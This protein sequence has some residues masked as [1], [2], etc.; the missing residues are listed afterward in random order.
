[1]PCTA[2]IDWNGTGAMVQAVGSVAAIIATVLIARS[3]GRATRD[4]LKSEVVRRTE[5]VCSLAWQMWHFADEV[6][7]QKGGPSEAPI[8]KN[9][10]LIF[11]L[12]DRFPVDQM[13]SG[14]VALRFASVR[15]LAAGFND[16]Y[17]GWIAYRT[18]GE[19]QDPRGF[20]GMV[21][22]SR[23]IA[24]HYDGLI[25]AAQALLDALPGKRVIIDHDQ[26]AH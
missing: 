1:M 2:N 8:P 3:D 14:E 9:L 12:V 11:E 4:L 13:P 22:L 21:E 16:S 6:V 20:Q 17:R 25:K 19:G 23:E 7:A 24:E 18:G 15:R 5:L 10:D 26:G